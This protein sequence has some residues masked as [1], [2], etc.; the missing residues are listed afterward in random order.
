MTSPHVPASTIPAQP[1]DERPPES[2]EIIQQQ[3]ALRTNPSARYGPATWRQTGVDFLYEADSILVREKYVDAAMV[4]LRGWWR[5]YGGIRPRRRSLRRSLRPD[6]VPVRI[7]PLVAG[8]R[9]FRMVEGWPLDAM[10]T[11]AII[12]GGITDS[13]EINGLGRGAA[14]LNHFCTISGNAGRCAPVEPAP[15][16][17]D[18]APDPPPAADQLAGQGVRV[19]VLDTGFDQTAA[20]RIPWLS[21]VV[22]EDDIGIHIAP[23]QP[24]TLDRYAGHG[25]FVAGVLR[26]V[27]PAADVRVL[28]PFTGTGEVTEAMLTLALDQCMTK[29]SPD[30]ISISAGTSTLDA[31]GSLSL[32]VFAEN[33]FADCK[34]VALV[35]AAGNDAHPDPF[36][37]AGFGPS[38]AVG[39]LNHDG[40]GM[41]WFSN[42]GGWVDVFAPGVD[43]VNAFPEGTYTYAEPP[44]AGTS[45]DFTGLA[46][47]S[48]TSF[49]TPL[50]AGLIA[51]RM[52]QTG[53]NGRDAAAD[54]LV[55]AQANAQPGVGAVLTP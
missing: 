41:A 45:A 12:L 51:A 39:A 33:L 7:E 40:I 31:T 1:R 27:A 21:G 28:A 4:N 43:L 9:M 8:V 37:P 36:Y 2:R 13:D 16:E 18:A 32:R 52:S 49:S 38:I 34:G 46:R 47:W 25:T 10:D 44:L 15:V 54:L 30:I 19:V 11:L 5:R 14:S 50:V 35:C 29:Y 22:G 20:Q 6:Q 24:T 17:P 26:C 3:Y 42:F 23:G 55:E 48:G 53:Q